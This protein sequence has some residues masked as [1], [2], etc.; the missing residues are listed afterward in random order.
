MK[1]K[2]YLTVL[3]ML[4]CLMGHA[5]DGDVTM[6]R[7]GNNF[8]IRNNYVSVY[9]NA[10]GEITSLIRYRNN[11]RDFSNSVQLIN[12]DGAKGYFSFA[13]SGSNTNYQ[14]SNVY[15]KQETADAVEVQYI[16]NWRDGIR[17]MIHYIVCRD[18]PGIYNYVQVEGSA[19]ASAL[20]E[21]RMCFRGN[22]SVFDYA[23]VNDEVQA[24]MPTPAAMQAAET[25]SDATFRLADGTI[26]TKYDYAAFQK[27]D[28]LHG[29]MGNQIGVWT[30]APSLEWINGGVM[31]QDLTVH[32]TESTPILLRHFHG[33][34]FGGFGVTFGS[35][36]T[37]LYGPHLIYINQSTAADV[38]TAHQEMI[39]DAKS[40]TI[41][42]MSAF[43]AYSWM[44][45]SG[46]KQR[47]T[48]TGQVTLGDD[49]DYFKTTK[50]QV[51]LAQ[52]GK[53]PM[54]QGNGY[55][56]WAETDEEGHFIVDKVRAGSYSLWVYALNGSATGY[57][58]KTDVTV[59]DQGTTDLG[60]LTWS[61]EK[62]GEHSKILWQ[63]GEADHL[64]DGYR[65]SG[66]KRQFGLW[67][68][69][70]ASLT[71]TIG[72]SNEATNWYY[73]QTKND[74]WIIN[75]QLNEMPTQPLRL[76]IA[77]AGAANVKMKVRSN[78]TKS[79]EGIGVFRP[80]HDGSVSRDA[81]LAGRDSLVVF[82]IPASTLKQGE[83]Y[84][85]LN[86]WGVPDSGMGGIMYDCIK[87]ES[88]EPEKDDVQTIGTTALLD[89]SAETV[90]NGSGLTE[91]V[92]YNNTGFYLRGNTSWKLPVRVPG[93]DTR[94]FT[95]SNNTEFKG[96]NYVTLQ[97][98]SKNVY[99]VTSVANED[100]VEKNR[101]NIGFRTT[102]AGK[103]YVAFQSSSNPA[104]DSKLR[105]AMNGTIIKEASLPTVAA[106]SARLDVLEYENETGG[107]F[108]IDS[109]N[110]A[111]NIFCIKFVPVGATG[112]QTI[113]SEQLTDNGYFD[114]QG[115][116]V[117]QPKKGLYILN[118]KKYIFR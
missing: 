110:S 113:Q 74:N 118:G 117:A 52:T 59:A 26:Y 39:A 2:I 32:A 82:E 38:A 10:N 111:S 97:G 84:L 68:E 9:I 61:P 109:Y 79:A 7:N 98:Q 33:N 1:E 20:S 8:T 75:Y 83:N 13:S 28:Q 92:N 37:K 23:Y 105:L 80:E 54:L 21:A 6:E 91:I 24:T 66:A 17:W 102:V 72:E 55:Q 19:S 99:N 25:I 57:Y 73:A 46:I 60:T 18:V 40:R 96:Q 107:T 71:Y 56:F 77:T 64:S 114:L 29:I 104:E 67:N 41:Q 94:T 50:F 43:P 51:V 81:T 103:I 106:K 30:I 44:R 15:L 63:I 27:D 116:R 87:L 36:Q 5:T 108:F 14:I 42:E 3:L 48:V 34:H 89:F 88:N 95:F 78:E 85:N 45:D 47:G 16:T 100:V 101:L 115:R 4:T 69:V 22:P 112:I 53:K 11:D 93:R 86:I 35:G 65:L 90:D 62:Y 76:T 49:A 58:E 12:D 70:P 31:R